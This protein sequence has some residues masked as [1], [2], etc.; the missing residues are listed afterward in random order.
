MKTI[1]RPLAWASACALAAQAATPAHAEQVETGQG[2]SADQG[3]GGGAALDEIIVT[4]RKRNE[5]ILKVPVIA[6]AIT[7]EKLANY[8]IA[9]LD[10]IAAQVT[11]LQVGAGS[12]NNG[13]QLSLR[14][15]GTGVTNPGVEQSVSLNIDGVQMTSG[16]AF[17]MGMFDLAQVEVLKGPQSLFFGK[18]SPGGVISLRTADPTDRF[19]LIGRLG[20][21]FE[22]DETLAELIASGPLSPQLGLRLAGSFLDS[23]GFFRNEAVG[24]TELGGVT[25][26]SRRF[27]PSEEYMLR[28]TLR[29]QPSDRFDARIKLSYAHSRLEGNSGQLISCP[30]GTASVSGRPF[31]A[32]DDCKADRVVRTVDMDPAKFPAIRNGGRAVTEYDQILG[33][34]EA[35]YKIADDI[36]LT[37]LTGLY[38]ID[39]VSIFNGANTGTAGPA[40]GVNGDF[41]RRDLTQELRLA[42]DFRD[43]PL[44]FMVGA[45]FQDGA[46]KHDF[47]LPANAAYQFPVLFGAASHKVDIQSASAFGQLLWKAL[48][49]LEISAGLRWTHEKRRHTAFDT[50]TG[51]KVPIALKRPEISSN[52][53]SPEVSITYTPSDDLTLFA[54]YKQGFKSGSFNVTG[55]PAKG[56]D[57]SFGDEKVKGVEAG[58]KTRLFDRSLNV[59]LGAYYYRY[60]DLQVGAN[61]S[62]PTTG[63]FGVRTLNAASANVYG[64][65]FDV[66][67]RPAAIEDLTLEASANW[68]RA[69]YRKFDSA[70]CWGGQLKS[71]GCD[72]FVNST[73]GRGNG[74]DLSGRELLRAPEWTATAGFDYSM[75]L[76]DGWRLELG[77]SLRYSSSYYTNFLLRDDMIQDG[78]F[79]LNARIAVKSEEDRWELALIG[80]NLN[81]EKICGNSANANYQNGLF[82]GGVLTGGD[83]RGP[84][85]IDELSCLIERG[86]EVRLRL[87]VKL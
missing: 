29:W 79:K 64:I 61:V 30:D 8:A 74:Q 80:N 69:R 18:N 35:N 60:S 47:D 70:P 3:A 83:T 51:A 32:S 15:V 33:S 45:F 55:T 21:E 85:G 37:S 19:E 50:I 49:Q 57:T 26:R 34:V 7:Q 54:S 14:G 4:A 84:A 81:N 24:V 44:N 87:S 52:N 25:P 31:I 59:N 27:A 39:Q 68:N 48:P 63:S 22:A 77:S 73:T 40:I 1:T 62:D 42:S 2:A 23:K 82:F 28:G 5:S 75:P 86:R 56:D 9:N 12:G 72:L 58:L 46:I 38:S 71:E 11:G 67:Y 17:K 78:Y 65:D 10:G 16:N 13:V 43:S 76:M 36:T 66:R 41:D 20:Y 6:T 53:A